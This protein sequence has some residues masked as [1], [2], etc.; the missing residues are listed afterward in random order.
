MKKI[1]KLITTIVTALI[2]SGCAQVGLPSGQEIS[3]ADEQA[4]ADMSGYVGHFLQSFNEEGCSQS[5]KIEM[6]F[7]DRLDQ[8]LLG[9]CRKKVLRLKNQI[10]I[11][12]V[13]MINSQWW[14]RLS[15]NSRM[16]LIAHELGHCV[17]D[18]KHDESDPIM[19]TYHNP[20]D[21]SDPRTV[22]AL[23]NLIRRHCY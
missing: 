4:A 16:T 10:R 21:W 2:S 8:K 6:M 5:F 19:P 13:V 9:V 11:E 23:K 15:S 22:S 18:A 14:G 20:L 12:G 17:L 3:Y 7:Y 1:T